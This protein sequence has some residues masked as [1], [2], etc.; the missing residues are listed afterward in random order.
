[1]SL[2]VDACKEHVK[3]KKKTA[4]NETAKKTQ[5]AFNL[6]DAI[7]KERAAYE[8][9]RGEEM[10]RKENQQLLDFLNSPEYFNFL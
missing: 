1:M 10:K 9:D 3:N 7:K 2:F 8:K 6:M 5:N 4:E